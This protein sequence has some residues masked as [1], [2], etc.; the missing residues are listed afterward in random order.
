MRRTPPIRRTLAAAATAS[1]L[2]GLGA[3]S[4]EEQ[5]GS[6]AATSAPTESTSEPAESEPAADQPPEGEVVDKKEFLDDMMAGLE[7]STTARMTMTSDVGGSG[8]EAEGVVD[9]TTEPVSMAM[10]LAGGAMGG[11]QS[12]LRLVDGI[13]YMNLGSMSNDKFI[14]LDLSDRGSL[15]PG[16]GAVGDQMDPLSSFEQLGPALK[17]VTFVGTED[18]DGEELR[19]YAVVAD[20]SKLESLQDAPSGSG[21]PAEVDYDLWF[22]D[23][24][25]MRRMEM[26][27]DMAQPVTVEAEMFDWGAPVDIE[28][29][30]EDQVVRPPQR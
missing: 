4:D 11:Q 14:R 29:P 22:D 10:T 6:G 12:D 30:P 3:C 15:P 2:L 8:I 23:R 1:L 20:T 9:Y 7:E 27:M 19:H 26:T 13:M 25:R 21:V 17:T 16:L 28:A 5:Q 24:F 18:V